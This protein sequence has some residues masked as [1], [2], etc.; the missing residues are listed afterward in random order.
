[1]DGKGC[2]FRSRLFF[3]SLSDAKCRHPLSHGACESNKLRRGTREEAPERKVEISAGRG[4]EGG[5]GQGKCLWLPFALCWMSPPPS[6]FLFCCFPSPF[7]TYLL[8]RRPA[9]FRQRLP[10]PA[11]KKKKGQAT[12]RP[13]L[14]MQSVLPALGYLS[15]TS[16]LAGPDC[17]SARRQVLTQAT[18]SSSEP[19]LTGMEEE[20]EEVSGL[21][22]SPSALGGAETDTVGSTLLLLPPPPPFLTPPAADE[23]L[24][25]SFSS[26]I[27]LSSTYVGI[28]NS[29]C[30]L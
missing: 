16:L 1:M 8:C 7:P 26:A 11:S 24:P 19:R 18:A 25:S 2:F 17:H 28:S 14:S 12:E 10:P 5:K 22:S 23:L 30:S 15:T 9:V 6:F 20:E 13:E 3:P 21:K 4:R 29:L 27:F